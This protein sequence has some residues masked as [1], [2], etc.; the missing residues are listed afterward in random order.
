M[1]V[2]F[3]DESGDHNL[4]VIDE[5]YPMFVLGG[6]IVDKDYAEGELTREVNAFKM[7]LFGRTDIVLHTADI[8]RNRNDF[9]PMKD[10]AFRARF[11]AALN[12]LMRRLQYSVVACAIRKGE[13]QPVWRGRA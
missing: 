8:T 2:L 6:I 3:L 1:K 9:K 10:A 12:H 7:A 13:H 5:R 4:S 11:Y